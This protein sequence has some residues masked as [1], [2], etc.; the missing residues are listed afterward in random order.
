MSS[1]STGSGSLNVKITSEKEVSLDFIV[2]EATQIWNKVRSKEIPY[3]DADGADK[4]MIE[5]TKEHPEFCESY[6]IV[7]RYICQMQEYCPKAFKRWLMK[8]KHNPWK[9]E[10]DYLDAQA[11]YVA[12]LYKTKHHYS[13]ECI[14]FLRANVR[15]ILQSELD[16]FKQRA[17]KISREIATRTM[18][19]RD[20]NIAELYEFAKLAGSAGISKAGSVTVV[21]DLLG[22]GGQDNV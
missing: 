1:Y 2:A 18:E 5:L 12:I 8:I 6:P 11:D 14:G 10:N 13:S 15:K 7:Y 22:R 19:L 16:I 9:T 4:I 20:N 17:E 3:E 21:S